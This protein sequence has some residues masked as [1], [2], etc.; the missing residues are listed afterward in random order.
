MSS[1]HA[2]RRR[3]LAGAL[4]LGAAGHIAGARR[5]FAEARQDPQPAPAAE[6]PPFEISIAE[7]SFHRMIRSGNFD[8]LSFA[9][10]ARRAYDVGAVEYVSQ[11]FAD[12]ATDTA[13]LNEM[14]QMAD[15]VD[16]KSLLIMIDGEGPLA[17]PDAAL[18]AEAIERHRKWVVAAWYLG[19]HSIRVN[20]AGA[21][22]FE[23]SSKHAADALVQLADYADQYAINVIVENHGGLSSNGKWL[24]GVMRAA[25]HP[26]VGTLPDFGNFRIQ[27]EEWYD[28]YEGVAE[29]MPW[30]KAVSAKSHDFDEQGNEVN[31]D[32]RRMLKIVVDAGYRGY[33]GIEYE[34]SG[35]P[36]Q[37]GVRLTL[38]LLKRVRD[39]LG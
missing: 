3:F 4:G 38:D 26:R 5:V 28:R 34:G 10:V 8:H 15:R 16:V 19:C 39:E 11:F 2:S 1:K 32:F 17:D 23:E 6:A 20:L 21:V 22:D 29:L 7:W 25:D 37:Q 24:A 12:K 31:T 33:V 36:E 9:S 35:Q 30:A 13:Y 14:R 18:R 27:G